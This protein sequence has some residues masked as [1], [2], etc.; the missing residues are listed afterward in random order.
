VSAGEKKKKRGRRGVG[1]CGKEE[2]AAGPA[3]P[4][5]KLSVFSFFFSKPFSKQFFFKRIQTKILQ[6]FHKIL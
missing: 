3:G 5:D 2:R 1:C 6:T 4:K